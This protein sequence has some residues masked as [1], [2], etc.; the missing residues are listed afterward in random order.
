MDFIA[1]ILASREVRILNFAD[2]LT[3]DVLIN[4]SSEARAKANQ[5]YFLPHFL[6]QAFLAGAFFAHLQLALQ[7][8]TYSARVSQNTSSGVLSPLMWL[9]IFLSYLPS[10]L[11]VDSL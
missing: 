11:A 1:K 4:E 3:A 6:A 5:N 2:E 8:F 9:M 10:T 7:N